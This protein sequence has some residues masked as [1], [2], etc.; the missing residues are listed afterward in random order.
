MD[1]EVAERRILMKRS[2]ERVFVGLAV[3]VIVIGGAGQWEALGD[4]KMY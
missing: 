2:I 3:A 4:G 1:E